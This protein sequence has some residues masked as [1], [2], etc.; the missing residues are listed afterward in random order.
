MS[1]ATPEDFR[2][3]NRKDVKL[4]SGLVVQIRRLSLLEIAARHNLLPV[5]KNKG[6]DPTEI[7]RDNPE[8]DI[9]MSN[10]LVIRG[11]V[12]PKIAFEPKNGEMPMDDLGAD[13]AELLNH[14]VA[15]ASGREEVD[16]VSFPPE[17]DHTIGGSNGKSVQMPASGSTVPI[18]R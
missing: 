6:K 9:K 14:I 2:K 1:Y 4:P 13:Y 18:D 5:G 12:Q 16:Q 8:A 11:T 7:V 10:E 17:G 3:R 15:F